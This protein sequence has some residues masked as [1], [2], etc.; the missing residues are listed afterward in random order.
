[1]VAISDSALGGV[2]PAA[3]ASAE[4]KSVLASLPANVSASVSE[5]VS[6][7]FA[8]AMDADANATLSLLAAAEEAACPASVSCSSVSNTGFQRRL[9]RAPSGLDARQRRLQRTTIVIYVN[10]RYSANM[11]APTCKE[12][13]QSVESAV[14]AELVACTPTTLA[15]EVKI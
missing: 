2:A 9:E 15:V 13:A 8:I 12:V 14:D 7:G 10:R 4:A 6:E 1:M 5:F 11:S 3:L